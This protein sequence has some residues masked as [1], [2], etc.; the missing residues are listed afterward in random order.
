MARGSTLNQNHVNDWVKFYK[1]APEGYKA[2]ALTAALRSDGPKMLA[3]VLNA[4][5][6]ESSSALVMDWESDSATKSGARPDAVNSP[7]D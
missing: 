5:G 4:L 6:L 3:A 2:K 1:S 7:G